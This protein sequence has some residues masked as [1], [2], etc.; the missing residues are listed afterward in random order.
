MKKNDPMPKTAK[1]AP[2][3]ALKLD[4]LDLQLA[5]ALQQDARLSIREL[6]RRLG[7][8]APT[9]SDRLSRLESAGVIQSYGTVVSL[10]ALG[11]GVIAFV[12]VFDTSDKMAEVDKWAAQNPYVLE[13]HHLTGRFAAILKV[14]VTDIT[15]L[16]TLVMQLVDMGVQCDTSIVLQSPVPHKLITVNP[17][18]TER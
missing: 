6:G 5:D 17:H 12:G 8:S 7:V 10:A 14:A 2:K 18:E 13:C 11:Y 4:P 3:T 15:A 1:S 9:I 16:N